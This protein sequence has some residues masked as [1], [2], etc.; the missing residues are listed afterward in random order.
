MSVYTENR[1]ATSDQLYDDTCKTNCDSVFSNFTV[2]SRMT[3]ADIMAC[4]SNMYQIKPLL[5]SRVGPCFYHISGFQDVS[6]YL[7][8]F[9]LPPS[10]SHLTECRLPRDGLQRLPSG[11]AR[12]FFIQYHFMHRC[13]SSGSRLFC[14]PVLNEAVL[15]LA[16][17]LQILSSARALSIM[18]GGRSLSLM[19]Q[20]VDP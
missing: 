15:L 12:R 3:C 9:V 18:S 10:I 11:S 8:H 7:Y 13:Y 19:L 14:E 6:R 17:N 4:V 5:G 20:E 1:S 2:P 16:L